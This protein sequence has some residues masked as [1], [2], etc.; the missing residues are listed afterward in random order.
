M[1]GGDAE[2][3]RNFSSMR[4]QSTRL[5]IG[6]QIKDLRE[7]TIR[8]LEG[9]EKL[10]TSQRAD[11]RLYFESKIADFKEAAADALTEAKAAITKAETA[12]EKRFEAV[13]EFRSTLSDQARLLM[14]R[15]E[16][17][18]RFETLAANVARIELVLHGA[19]ENTNG[20]SSTGHMFITTGIAIFAVIT[21]LAFSGLAAFRATPNAPAPIGIDS[22][23]VDDL[24]SRI[25]AMSR[26][27][28]TLPSPSA[29][30]PYYPQSVPQL[31]VLPVVPTPR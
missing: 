26:R 9:V 31:N 28:D 19:V 17:D 5:E 7:L 22:K 21:S 14:P 25:D 15:A 20:K 2:M 8:D 30:L 18:S 16:A 10:L 3:E 13:N 12:T 23:R 29:P 4:E 6:K 11:D 1:N 24:V 27:V